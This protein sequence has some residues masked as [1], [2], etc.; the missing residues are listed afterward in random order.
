MTAPHWASYPELLVREQLSENTWDMIRNVNA[1]GAPSIH[2]NVATLW[3]HLGH[4]PA[5]LSLAYT[6][7]GPLHAR[8]DTVAATSSMVK[9]T[10]VEAGP[11]ASW[12]AMGEALSEQA[13]ATITAYVTTQTQVVRMV[14]LG[15]MLARWL[16]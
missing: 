15:H 8:G 1:F 12:R 2:A 4:W 13:R 11:L 6:G 5:L 10:Q 9:L 3:R 7:L 14:T 16:A